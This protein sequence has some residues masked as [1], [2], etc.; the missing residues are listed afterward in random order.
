MPRA[1]GDLDDLVA[2]HEAHHLHDE[3]IELA[4]LKAER[5]RAHGRGKADGVAVMVSAPDIDDAVK[6]ALDELVAV[7]GDVDRI[8]GIKA[9][10]AAQDL[11]LVGAEV[12]V[13]QPERAVL[14]IRQTGIRE[15]LHGL[16]HVAGAMQ[17]ALEEPLVKVDA[18]ALKVALHARD[19]VR[20]AEGH[21]RRAALGARHGEVLVAVTLVDELGER[22]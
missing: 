13:A 9:V 16:G 15:Q 7:I 3:E 20:Q 19:V 11:V 4:S 2:A 10:R 22:P 17:A 12:G 8:V 18:V 14:F 21:E 6:A 1:L 5:G